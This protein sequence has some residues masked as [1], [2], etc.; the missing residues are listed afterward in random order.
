MSAVDQFQTLHRTILH[1]DQVDSLFSLIFKNLNVGS[2]QQPPPPP[3]FFVVYLYC[4]IL[5]S[6]MVLVHSTT[7]PPQL[8]VLEITIKFIQF[9][10]KFLKCGLVVDSS[11]IHPSSIQV[12]GVNLYRWQ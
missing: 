6:L 7:I 1:T 4:D 2:T 5:W 9:S 8:T 10:F 3:P 11:S 12:D